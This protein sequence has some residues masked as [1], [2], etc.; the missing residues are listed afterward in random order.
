MLEVLRG[1]A[2]RAP[3]VELRDESAAWAAIALVGRRAARV[4]AA[5]GALGPD[6]DVRA[7][8][9]FASV[10]IGGVPVDVLLQS[11]RRALLLVEPAGA[12]LVWRA[13]EAAG[14]PLGMSCVGSEAVER[15]AMLE[16]PALSLPAVVAA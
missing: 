11:D 12:D 7:A 9:P 14:R 4:L 2:G 13:C 16:R 15:F 1:Q 3:G 10:H 8:R 6:G 5:L